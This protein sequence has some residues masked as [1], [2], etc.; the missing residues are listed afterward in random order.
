MSKLKIP[1]SMRYNTETGETKFKYVEIEK[2]EFN[3]AV[4]KIFAPYFKE[5]AKAGLI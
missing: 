5:Q 2:E 3:R 1:V 4:Q